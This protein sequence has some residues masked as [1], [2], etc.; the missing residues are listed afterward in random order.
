MA[1]VGMCVPQKLRARRGGDGTH[2]HFMS[3]LAAGR[4]NVASAAGANV[5]IHTAAAQHFL[6]LQN[7]FRQRSA[8][9]QVRH[10]VPP[11]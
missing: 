10:F 1:A 6:K 11:D 9:R 2:F 7:M 8:K 5:G 4:G 3:K